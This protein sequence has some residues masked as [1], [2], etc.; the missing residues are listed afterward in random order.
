LFIKNIQEIPG[1]N[2]WHRIILLGAFLVWG[3]S[4]LAQGT[5]TSVPELMGYAK[6]AEADLDYD[7]AIEFWNTIIAHP[8]VNATQRMEASVSA[9][10][11]ERI[12][13]KSLE[14]RIHF[15]YV[16]KKDIAHQLPKETEPKIKDFFELVRKEVKAEL[17]R[18][19]KTKIEL[20][21]GKAALDKEK[22]ALGQ[23]KAALKKT[24]AE[25]DAEKAALDAEKN[26]PAKTLVI[27][28]KEEVP[29]PAP[30][31]VEQKVEKKGM[32][33]MTI[34]GGTVAALGAATLGLGGIAAY[35]ATTEQAA[36]LATDIQTERGAHYDQRN[37]YI[38]M[39]NAGYVV[40][41]VLLATGVALIAV[42]LALGGE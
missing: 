23:E 18:Q 42:D 27:T 4:A 6:A 10:I 22:A 20:D 35:L 13:G 39:G 38:G 33:G 11:I 2:P 3:A 32:G 9:G 30:A 14:A 41:G 15:Q 7:R 12:R 25:L 16:L 24:K 40:G 8:D 19:G 26:K 34:M 31:A 37:L 36:A 21:A 17:V 1:M 29:A 5:G 28:Q